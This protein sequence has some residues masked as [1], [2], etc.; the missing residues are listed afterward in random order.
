M[1]QSPS[2]NQ[3]KRKADNMEIQFRKRNKGACIIAQSISELGKSFGCIIEKK[4]L[5]KCVKLQII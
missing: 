5:K 2:I 4:T 3:S 1:T